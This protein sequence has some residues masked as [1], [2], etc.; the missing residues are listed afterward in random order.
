M[1]AAEL[2]HGGVFDPTAFV[3]DAFAGEGGEDEGADKEER[4]EGGGRHFEMER[5]GCV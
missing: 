5:S 4:G 1:A 2:G 3:V